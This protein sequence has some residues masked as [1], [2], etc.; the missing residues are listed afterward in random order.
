MN[1]TKS[2][3]LRLTDGDGGNELTVHYDNRGDPYRK[4]VSLNFTGDR[5]MYFVFLE[6]YEAGRLRDL[7]NELLP[8]HNT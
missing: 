7:L 8:P 4:G 6:D 5:N 1:V 3:I 2:K